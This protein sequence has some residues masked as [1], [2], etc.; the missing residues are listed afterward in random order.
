MCVVT[1]G[2]RFPLLK[3]EV[4]SAKCEVQNGELRN[5]KRAL[6]E[7]R[8]SHF[9]S[10]KCEIRISHFNLTL[11]CELRISHFAFQSESGSVTLAHQ[12]PSM[13]SMRAPS[14]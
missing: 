5:A 7:M 1:H 13:P 6:I 4:P 3:C 10:L 2:A 14:V 9:R 12:S 11:K 8:N